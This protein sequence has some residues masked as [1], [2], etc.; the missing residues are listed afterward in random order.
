ME[1]QIKVCRKCKLL[2]KVQLQETFCF[3]SCH[4]LK[5]K[6]IC[7]RVFRKRLILFNIFSKLCFP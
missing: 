1:T 7:K 3:H 5:E 4:V 6:N 2:Q